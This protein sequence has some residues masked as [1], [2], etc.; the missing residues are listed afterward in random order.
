MTIFY[1][2]TSPVFCR[3]MFPPAPGTRLQPN[4]LGQWKLQR[5][6]TLHATRKERKNV[7]SL[8]IYTMNHLNPSWLHVRG[9]LSSQPLH[10]WICFGSYVALFSLHV[11]SAVCFWFENLY[12]CCTGVFLFK[13]SLVQF[14]MVP[15]CS[16]KLIIMC[17]TLSLR[18]FPALPLKQLQC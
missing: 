15:M 14:R 3:L 10:H 1:L 7:L 2:D 17:S 18:S 4:W 16:E 5:I 6:S 9:Y 11:T 13:L 8:Y 12:I